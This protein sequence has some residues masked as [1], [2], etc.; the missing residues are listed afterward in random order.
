MTMRAPT[1]SVTGH[2]WLPLVAF[3]IAAVLLEATR[4]DLW[5]ADLL[6][7]IEGGAWSLRRDPFVRDVL[8]ND[9]SRV[10]SVLYALLLVVCATSF[11]T[12]R[13]AEYRR[14]LVYLVVAI[15][16][17][18][19]LVALLKDVTHVNCP[20]SVDRYG[21]DVAYLPTLREILARGPKGRCF[22]SGHASSGFALFAFYFFCRIHA[23][24]LRWYAFGLAMAVGLT[25]GIAQ[26]LRGAHYVSHD[27][28]AMAICWFVA[29]AA[30]PILHKTGNA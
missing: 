2:V 29:V 6:Y 7:R 15:A 28:W 4:I 8:H 17:S 9:A 19:L 5:L 24:A 18:T 12:E 16:G 10:I 13:L 23:P 27:I 14:G 25:F 30:T 20:W 26:Q 22:P 21:G 11:F 3:V 1:G